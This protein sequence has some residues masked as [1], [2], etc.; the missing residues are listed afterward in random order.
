MLFCGTRSELRGLLPKLA[1]HDGLADLDE[2]YPRAGSY[3]VR[4]LR[5]QGKEQ[6]ASLVII[7]AGRAGV[8]KALGAMLNVLTCPKTQYSHWL[9]SHTQI[10]RNMP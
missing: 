10:R 1:A 9:V 2:R 5:E 6:P 8:D 3:V 4:V 7:G